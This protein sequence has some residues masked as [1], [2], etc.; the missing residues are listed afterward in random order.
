MLNK[1]LNICVMKIVLDTN[2]LISGIFWHGAPRQIL[3]LWAKH[4]LQLL[5]TKQI[6]IEY[7]RVLQ[8]IHKRDPVINI[9]T[10]IIIKN[11]IIIQD[12]ELTKIC[13]DVDDNKF[14]NCALI[15]MADYLISGDRDLLTIKIVGKTKIISPARFLKIFN[16][17]IP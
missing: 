14:L 3:T 7:I 12:K 16:K 1:S 13:R 6:F 10:A 15:G 8:K 9:W 4:K 5:I 11:S 2:V 17:R